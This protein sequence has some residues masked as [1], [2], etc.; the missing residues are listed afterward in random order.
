MRGPGLGRSGPVDFNK[1][2]FARPYSHNSIPTR[3]YD[4]RENQIN[5][6]GLPQSSIDCTASKKVNGF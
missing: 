4:D 1:N 5:L 6:G 2:D 3:T